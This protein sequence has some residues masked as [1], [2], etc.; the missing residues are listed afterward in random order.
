MYNN[1]IFQ[2]D[3]LEYVTTKAPQLLVWSCM[4]ELGYER[5]ESRQTLSTFNTQDN[6]DWDLLVANTQYSVGKSLSRFHIN[7]FEDNEDGYLRV[8]EEYLFWYSLWMYWW[9]HLQNDQ[10]IE[11]DRMIIANIANKAEYFNELTSIQPVLLSL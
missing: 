1:T 3:R 5:L 6:R 4:Q 11:M 7:T 8:T 9:D 2:D 10:R